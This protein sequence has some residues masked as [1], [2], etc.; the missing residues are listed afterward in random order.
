[1]LVDYLAWVGERGVLIAIISKDLSLSI[2]YLHHRGERGG[3]KR[4]CLFLWSTRM[5]GR[6]GAKG[7]NLRSLSREEEPAM[8]IRPPPGFLGRV[9]TGFWRISGCQLTCHLLPFSEQTCLF[10]AHK[11]PWGDGLW[12]GLPPREDI[13]INSS[14]QGFCFGLWPRFY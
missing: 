14:D 9:V 12:H 10:K 3:L 13:G 4:I 5:N 8:A 1:M 11:T 7:Q 6:T 2:C